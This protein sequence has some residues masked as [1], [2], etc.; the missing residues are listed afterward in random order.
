MLWRG[1]M[2]HSAMKQFL[3]DV[4]WRNVDYLIVDMPPGTGDIALSLHQTVPVAGAVLVT[5]PQSVS[6]ADTKRAIQMYRKLN[7]PAIGLIENMSHFVCPGCGRDSD[8]FGK[9]GGERLAAE[10]SV[11]FLGHI[12]LYEPVRQ[13]SDNGVP[14]VIGD[15]QSP[16][17]VAIMAAAERVAQQVS[18]AS[19]ARR[20]MPLHAV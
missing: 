11:P 6:V 12:P 16:P 8:I 7:I 4:R 13:A 2:L 19:F 10:M 3:R 20:A 9:G 17:A 18:I 5:T 15:P 14:V 1:P